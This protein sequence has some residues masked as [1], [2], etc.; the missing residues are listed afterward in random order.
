[1]II[2]H[3]CKIKI[4]LKKMK[5]FKNQRTY[6]KVYYDLTYMINH[7]LFEFV[8]V[9][10]LIIVG[11]A[12]GCSFISMSYVFL[13]DLVSVFFT[14][15]VYILHSSYSKK[16]RIYW[17]ALYF[18]ILVPL[19]TLCPLPKIN[20]SVCMLNFYI[21]YFCERPSHTI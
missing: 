7:P 16:P 4:R 8:D 3:V 18:H 14:F 13:H 20:T 11:A 1:M 5:S 10:P 9:F 21:K 2:I 17:N 12:V 15:P 6:I 19:Y